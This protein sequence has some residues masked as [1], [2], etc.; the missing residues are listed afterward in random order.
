MSFP[1]FAQKYVDEWT[2]QDIQDWCCTVVKEG[3]RV[4]DIIQ[5]QDLVKINEEAFYNLFPEGYEVVGEELWDD[6][7]ERIR[8]DIDG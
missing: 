1:Q 4:V 2:Q 8:P 6:L 7:V 3:K 5:R